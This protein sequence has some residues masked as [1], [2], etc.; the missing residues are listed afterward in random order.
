MGF[1]L[2]SKNDVIFTF[3]VAYGDG[4]QFHLTTDPLRAFGKRD[5]EL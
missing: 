4:V 2:R 5:T 3:D 1:I